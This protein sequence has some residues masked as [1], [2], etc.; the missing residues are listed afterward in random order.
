MLKFTEKLFGWCDKLLMKF[1]FNEII[2]SYLGLLVNLVILFAISYF[3]YIVFRFILVTIMAIVA[4]KTKTKFDDLLVSNQTAKYISHLIPL[5]YVY[6]SVPVILE[7]FNSWE[8]I[9]GKLV[10]IYIILLVLWIIRAVFNVLRDHLKTIPSYSDKPIDSYIQVI[11]IILWM[12][13][14]TAILSKLFEI[15]IRDLLTTFG[16]ISAIILLIFRDTILGFVASIQVSVNDMVRIGDW[17]TMDKFGADG[18]V[19]EI[20]L[21]TVKVRNFDN[22]TTTI[23]TYSLISDSFRN[24]RGMLNADGRRIKRHILIK[25]S[26]IRFVKEEELEDFKQIQLIKTYIEK[27]QADI[28]KYN[29]QYNVDKSLSVNGRNLT[30][31]GLF[32]K[33]LTNYLENYPSLNKDMILLCRHL[34]PTAQ[35]V[36][37]EIYAFTSDK[38]FENY[39]YI[40]SDIFD[41]ILASVVYFD[42]EIFEMPSHKNGFTEA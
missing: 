41:H 39:E 25:S 9:F 32:R 35:G 18:D 26:S 31:F 42:L 37:L 24:W 2:A 40:M 28:N 36:P 38:R 7:N 12:I 34:Q 30:N 29:L 21:A 13:G 1:G 14:F 27:K 5:I 20:N 8:S 11:M 3:L 6:K 4:R 15:E 10:G 17:I 19:I 33:Y 22:T 23:P 16:A